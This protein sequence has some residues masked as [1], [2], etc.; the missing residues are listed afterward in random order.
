MGEGILNLFSVDRIFYLKIKQFFSYIQHTVV[1]NNLHP[2]F[3]QLQKKPMLEK[4]KKKFYHKSYTAIFDRLDLP[5]ILM[6]SD[7]YVSDQP[8]NYG[9]TPVP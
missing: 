8:S 7:S 6:I 5:Q 9:Q 1:A 4:Y 3:S 2:D